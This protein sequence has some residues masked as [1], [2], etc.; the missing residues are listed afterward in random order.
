MRR[1]KEDPLGQHA[2]TEPD[3]LDSF[4]CTLANL[5]ELVLACLDAAGARSVV[6]VGAEHGLFTRELLAWGA[7]VQAE[8]ITAIDPDPQP[9]LLALAEAEPALELIRETSDRGLAG[10]EPTDAVIL[11]GDHNYFTVSEELRQIARQSEGGSFPLVLLHDI[12]WP[13]GRRD[14][15]HDASRMAPEGVQPGA[16]PGFLDPAEPGLA[17]RGL[18]YACVAPSAGG[19]RNGVLTAVE[20]FIGEREGLRLAQVPQFFGLGVVWAED[21]PWAAALE[22]TIGPW[23]SHPL[24]QRAEEKRIEH[25]VAEFR[26]L[27]QIDAMRSE[28]YELQHLLATM[29]ESSAFAMAERLSRL[30]QGGKPMFTRDQV[31]AALARAREDNDLLESTEVNADR[32]PPRG[33]GVDTP[34]LASGAA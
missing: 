5:A 10:L 16:G 11:D 3:R 8:R 6:E 9:D 21:A 25:L 4:D 17:N 30:K 20:D 15:Y 13:L 18:Y 24:L 22:K 26:L 31:A 19:P 23:D 2:W 12:G 7:R 34:G 14:S 28:D 33:S 32:T 1:D 27:Q 29:L